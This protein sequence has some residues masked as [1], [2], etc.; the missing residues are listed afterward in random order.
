MNTLNIQNKQNGDLLQADEWNQLVSKTNELVQAVN[1]SGGA[2]G[3][4]SGTSNVNITDITESG[5]DPKVKVG[6]D[7]G[8]NNFGGDTSVISP[9]EFT[10][11]VKNN[12]YK[13]TNV[14]IVSNNNINIEPRESVESTK[15]GN[16]SLK[17]GD[18]IELCSHHRVAAN[19]DEV[20]VKVID[21]E[22]NPVKLQLN[23][24]EITLTTKDKQGDNANVFDINV[25]SAKNTKGYLKVRAQAID[26][27]SESHGGIAL[28]PKGYDGEGHMNKIKFEHGGGDGLEF[29]TFNTEKSSLFTNEYRFKRNGVWKM[30]SRQ[31]T[32]SD[33][34][35]FT[36]MLKYLGIKDSGTADTS[37]EYP[38]NNDIYITTF[39]SN[40]LVVNQLYTIAQVIDI[41]PEIDGESFEDFIESNLDSTIGITL[42][43]YSE[44]RQPDEYI[45]TGTEATFK[46]TS[47]ASDTTTSFKY[48]KQA[49]D[50]YDII[51]PADPIA[52]TEEIVMAGSIVNKEI[53]DNYDFNIIL[54]KNRAYIPN[55]NDVRIKFSK[56]DVSE[57]TGYNDVIS[58]N[59]QQGDTMP[60]ID[61]SK[62]K[63]YTFEE[64]STLFNSVTI[65]GQSV[66][67]LTGIIQ[68]IQYG[69]QTNK[70]VNKEIYRL[71]FVNVGSSGAT[72]HPYVMEILNRA[73]K[74][75]KFLCQ[76]GTKL[77]LNDDILPAI[78]YYKTQIQ[79][80]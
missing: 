57:F 40:S 39:N 1:N 20:S 64:V 54:G 14:S 66:S 80:Q 21:G 11:K 45:S 59:F 2:S 50:F 60:I 51:N 73:P 52:T 3:G 75:I 25:N 31:V 58:L 16:I 41:A 34:E 30:A 6:I 55:V 49:D 12:N 22:D 72:T 68:E 71:M 33:K 53:S 13:G 77:S 43:D 67:A 8:V 15:G 48:V 5:G 65:S 44:G 4:N 9:F 61:A 69:V 70:Q 28:Q 63:I 18:D 19:Q 10:K 74:D 78:N 42:Y 36:I 37:Y 17:P 26:L 47:N 23:A 62:N 24:S 76:D 79:S 46:I 7:T 29:G 32:K 35:E 27:R 38:E 56:V